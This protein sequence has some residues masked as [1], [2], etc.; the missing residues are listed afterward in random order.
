M[1]GVKVCGILI[2]ICLIVDVISC[3][4]CY[5]YGLVLQSFVPQTFRLWSWLMYFSLGGLIA[6]GKEIKISPLFAVFIWVFNAII[7]YYLLVQI[8]H[9]PAAEY[10]YD[11]I[12]LISTTVSF[13]VAFKNLN[14]KN[15]MIKSIVSY[16]G[17]LVMGVYIIHLYLM[18]ICGHFIPRDSGI[19]VLINYIAVIIASFGVTMIIRKIPF[20]NK[21]IQL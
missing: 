12:L 16:F 3:T 11:N 7:A 21:M 19:L 9:I 13:F 5:K 15:N 14:I 2:V 4:M 1:G 17:N 10:L 18:T 20:I 8:I 6:S